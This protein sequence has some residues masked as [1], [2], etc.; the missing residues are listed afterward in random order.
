MSQIIIGAAIGY[1]ACACTVLAI[2]LIRNHL[3]K[4]DGER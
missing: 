4:K 1:V 3:D 2:L